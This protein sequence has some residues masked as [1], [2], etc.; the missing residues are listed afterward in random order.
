MHVERMY[1]QA[2]DKILGQFVS[3]MGITYLFL[4]LP[5]GFYTIICRISPCP[6]ML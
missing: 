1:A 2:I 4:M 3:H 6:M 5:S